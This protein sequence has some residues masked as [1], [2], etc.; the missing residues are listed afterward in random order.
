MFTWLQPYLF[1]AKIG[2]IL[3][4]AAAAAYGS[5]YITSDHYEKV[6]AENKVAADAKIQEQLIANQ[7]LRDEKL[8][9]IND[10]ET[11]HEQDQLVVNNLSTQLA[12][13]RIHIPTRG[14]TV[15]RGNKG[16]SDTG[17][18][19]GVLSARVD[20]SFARL[21]ARANELVLRCDQLNND[22]R[23]ANA[24]AGVK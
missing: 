16:G 1:W 13:M 24:A 10:S 21:Q 14:C 4:L 15:P 5:W 23:R 19:S 17:G 18:G 8:K 22:A 12:G 11:Q 7:K 3:G 6:I 9:L 20:E 2:A